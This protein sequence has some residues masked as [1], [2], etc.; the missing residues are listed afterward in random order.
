MIL[1]IF[2]EQMSHMYGMYFVGDPN[3][4]LWVEIY[5]K[6]N[7][8]QICI[9]CK[10]PKRLLWVGYFFKQNKKRQPRVFH[11]NR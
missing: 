1:I 11:P 3:S 6:E 2:G 10:D 4:P 8:K 9:F 7:K 5:F